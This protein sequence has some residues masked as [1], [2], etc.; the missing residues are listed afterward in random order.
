MLLEKEVT[1]SKQGGM[2]INIPKQMCKILDIHVGDKLSLLLNSDVPF[3]TMS[4]VNES[5]IYK[6]Q[7]PIYGDLSECLVYDKDKKEVFPLFCTN[8]IMAL[9]ESQEYKIYVEGFIDS[10]K[11]F[12]IIRKVKEQCW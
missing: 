7:K 4:K 6:I 11:N 9:F 8:E 5:K 10:D 1:V 2:S 3:I 12:N